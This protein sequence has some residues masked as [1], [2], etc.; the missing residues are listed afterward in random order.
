MNRTL[1]VGTNMA[2]EY[3]F[4]CQVPSHSNPAKSYTIKMDEHGFLSCN[5]PSWIFNH[6]KDRTCKHIDEIRDK[7]DIDLRGLVGRSDGLPTVC[8]NYPAKCDECHFRF[9]CYT[10][11]DIKVIGREF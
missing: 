11:R 10:S 4:V 9:K 3:N 5:C 8:Y 7:V 1:K 2:K 6:R